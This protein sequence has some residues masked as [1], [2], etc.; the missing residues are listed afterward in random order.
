VNPIRAAVERPYI[1][2]VGVI[3]TVLF[4]VLAYRTIPVQLKPTV[5]RPLI[6]VAT[7]F[8]GASAV[9]V[10][11]QITRELED[12]LAAVE[13]VIEMTSESTEGRSQIT[14][15]Y[16]LGTDTQLAV[17]DVVNKL[18]QVQ[19]LP[20]EA[21]EP[22]VEVAPSDSS[23][24]MW[25][26]LK[27]R[28]DANRVR[29]IVKDEIESRLQRVPGVANLLVVGGEENEV[30]VR[31]DPERL[32]AFGVSF[33][34]L[35]R[36]LAAGNV[37]V[38]G[39]SVETASRQLVVR[40][41]GMAER[42]L[43]LGDIIV[44]QEGAGAVKLSDVADVVDT[45]RETSSF[46]SINGVPGVAIGLS[47]KSGSNVVELI[48]RVDASCAELNE[49]FARRG[50]D[51]FLTPVYRESNY[52]FE[53]MGFVQDNLLVGALLA[54]VVL[55]AFLRSL[56]SVLIVA[57]S[58]PLSLVAVFLV[59]SLLGRTL[60]VISLAGLA[61]A[62]GMVVDNAIVV[63]ENVFRHRAM[64][65]S[66]LEASVDGGREVW[67]GV[68]ASTLTTVAVFIPI[69]LQGDEASQLFADL[70]LAISAAVLLSLVVSLSVVP[71][72]TSMWL[73]SD[74]AKVA[75]QADEAEKGS[76]GAVGRA[77]GRLIGR[78][79]ARG[80]TLGKLGMV[81]VAIAAS[82]ATIELAPPTEYLP[83]GSRNLVFFFASPIPGTRPEQ[84]RDNFKPLEKFILAQPETDHSFTV[85]G[86]RFNGGG[87]VLKQE[88]ADG[89]TIA[90]FHGRLY[91]PATSLA[92]FQF[93]VPV[94][95]SLFEDPGKQF[96]IELSGPD[97]DTLERASGQLQQ[98]LQGL[99]GVQFVRS[100]LVTGRPE[101]RVVVDEHRAKDLGLTVALVGD[102]VET[103]VAG[104]RYTSLIEGGRDV[105][106]NLLVA[107]ERIDSPEKLAALRFVAPNGKLVT[108]A[109][110][111]RVE[112]TTGP[113]S[114]RRLE[115]ERN[116]LLTVNIAQ[117]A[118]LSSVVEAVERDVFPEF[119]RDLGAAYT[120]RTGGSADKLRTTLG[121]LTQGFGLSVL[122]IYLLMV[123]L[124][125]SWSAPFVILTSVPLAL[126]G[127]LLGIRLAH[128]WSGGQANLDV[129]SMLGFVILAGLVVNNAIL[130]VHQANNFRA[131]GRSRREALLHSCQT[132]LRPILMTVI[133]TVA[134]MIPL[135]A[136]GDSGAELYQGL[137][138]VIVGGLL[139]S[140]LFTLVLVPIVLSI[141][142]D[143][144][145]RKS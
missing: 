69:L 112:R 127:G 126:S 141:G 121:S 136:G 48:E 64:G 117:D 72:M 134:G 107:Q 33:A 105:D 104:R 20:E 97:F 91:G 114:V 45:Y 35:G 129:I 135:A 32:A 81:L 8:R 15:E 70:A 52:I 40:T 24:V 131:E 22:Q 38:R 21:D 3:L 12:V 144:I 51:V 110:V 42:P 28:Y 58:I 55:A 71:V 94:R 66:L 60:N 125:S 30:Q 93:V 123:A 41:V 67:G 140:T 9:E 1:T 90:N 83:T 80:G 128:E 99:Q 116:V 106:V 86:P 65:K 96:E 5:D 16:E 73:D 79:C 59:M 124:F 139:L 101:L 49:I 68:L 6:T 120:L 84:A 92:G 53:A 82:L 44:R 122:I 89:D 109:S 102:V 78:I 47:R 87:V 118:P 31:V 27:S 36:A 26:A 103:A 76:L 54:V 25:I 142:Y 115:R 50:V 10:E 85:I 88:F 133:T 77:Y 43:L 145:E 39:G 130:I 132:R 111:A 23:Q 13:G 75:R 74:Q 113:E 100:S 37:N 17:I 108:L 56:R 95:S 143:W 63:L 34:D 7:N 61:F 137:G 14:L 138:A 19:R 4:S 18:T 11:Q 29:R 46:V 98:R 62:S 119:A 57:L 2:A